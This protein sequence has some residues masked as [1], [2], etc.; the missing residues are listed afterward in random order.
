MKN[1]YSVP[2]QKGAIKCDMPTMKTIS[3]EQ[4]RQQ[5]YEDRKALYDGQVL[6]FHTPKR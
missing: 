3:P 1:E 2:V 6:K 5:D 4:I